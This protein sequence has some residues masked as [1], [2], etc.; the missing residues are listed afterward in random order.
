MKVAQ[1][2]AGAPTGGAELFFERLT[3]ALHRA[4]DSVLPVIRRNEPRAARLARAGLAPRQLGFGGPADLLTGPRLRTLLRRFGPRVVVAW[5]NRAASFTPPGD[6]VLAGRL[7]G[8]YDLDYYRRC[9]HLVGNTRGIVRWIAGQGWA[10]RRVHYV[11]NFV[12]DL[13]GATPVSRQSLGVPPDCKLVL[14]LGRLHRNK[15]FDMLISALPR[16][17]GT[18]AVIAG[19]GPERADLLDAARREGVSDRLHLIGWREDT[20]ALLAA[21]DALVCPSRHEPLGNVVIEAWSAGRPVVAAASEGP[22]ELITSDDGVLVPPGDPGALA[23]A[24][25]HVLDDPARAASLTR[26]GRRRFE[27]EFAEA[28]VVARWREFLGAVEK[29]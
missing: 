19:E 17:P 3:T 15:A 2:M 13:G 12:D 27:T 16:L 4:G 9:D 1:V 22:R 8:Y 21:A 25:A 23:D 11:P 28:P 24:L 7:G 5:M 14:A 29:A 6:W 10:D 18:H 20:G 26:T